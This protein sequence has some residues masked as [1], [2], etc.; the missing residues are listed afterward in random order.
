[1]TFL[2]AV[3]WSSIGF[4]AFSV[5][6]MMMLIMRKRRVLKGQLAWKQRKDEVVQIVLGA[7]SSPPRDDAKLRIS[8]GRDLRLV[9]EI[10]YDLSA[11]I[12]GDMRERLIAMLEQVGGREANI[13]Q[14]KSPHE[15]LRV[16]AVESLTLFPRGDDVS[17]ALMVALDDIS[18]R[19]RIIAAKALVDMGAD[20]SVT[21]VIE[22]FSVSGAA[23][24]RSLREIVRKLAPHSVPELLRISIAEQTHSELARLLAIDALG[25]AHDYTVLPY[26]RSLFVSDSVN[27][28]AEVLRALT[29]IGHPS[30]LPVVM[31]GLADDTWIVRSQAAICAGRIGLHDTIPLLADH[32]EDPEWWARYRAASALRQIGDDGLAALKRISLE[33][34][35][36][37][38]TAQMVLQEAG[39]A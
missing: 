23:N 38:L 8:G 6:A 11:S 24:P 26:L 5:V 22:K 16:Q 30:A 25:T 19:V 39:L 27:I 32:L 20:L 29:N 17:N 3:W 36:A 37:G 13:M 4:S 7:L 18:P 31:M 10:A 34:S 35:D 15:W 14:L 9:S 33:P 12:R 28:R 1:M 21:Q 2:Q